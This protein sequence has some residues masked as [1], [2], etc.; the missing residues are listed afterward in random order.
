[1]RAAYAALALGIVGGIWLATTVLSTGGDRPATVAEALGVEPPGQALDRRRAEATAALVA[2]CMADHGLRWTP[3]VEPPPAVPDPDLRPVEW[4]GRWGFGA[5]TMVGRQASVTAGDPNLAAI[6]GLPAVK[7]AAYLRA[8]HG[9]GSAPGCLTTASKTV[10][11]L[12]DRL[13]APLRSD[14]QAL[15]ALIAASPAATRALAAW[16]TCVGPVATG[17]TPD[18]RTLP[19]ALLERFVDRTTAVGP[20]I[21]GVVGLAALQADE[22]R[23]ATAVARCELAVLEERSRV[24][25]VH[26]A[27]FVEEHRDALASIGAAIRAAEAA[28]PTLPP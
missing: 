25:S 17:L 23:V 21:A 20:G 14:L 18:R 9:D 4:A 2:R 22:R 5:S 1:V 12:R 26:E 6:A 8:L 11:G 24:A 16:R 19:G 15:D 10:Y 28:L 13:L 3:V 27:A 7:R